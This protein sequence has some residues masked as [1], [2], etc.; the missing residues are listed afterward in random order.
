M[1]VVHE[2]PVDDGHFAVLCFGE[3]TINVMASHISGGIRYRPR[4]GS[5]H[6]ACVH[7]YTDTLLGRG[8]LCAQCINNAI[9]ATISEDK[10]VLP[11]AHTG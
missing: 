8:L 1:D 2:Q 6:A 7:V 10:H 3:I 9:K 4:A 11:D 5:T